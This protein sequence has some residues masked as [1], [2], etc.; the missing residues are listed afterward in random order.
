MQPR[1]S[2]K[3]PNMLG[4]ERMS[5]FICDC[6]YTIVRPSGVNNPLIGCYCGNCNTKWTIVHVQDA[7]G[8][9][10]LFGKFYRCDC[11]ANILN[12]PPKLTECICEWVELR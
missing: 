7:Q 11:D 9:T 12:R 4:D 1:I 5:D 10:K 3:V 2:T 8:Q 6:G